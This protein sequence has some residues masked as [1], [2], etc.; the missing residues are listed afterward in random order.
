MITAFQ[1]GITCRL[2]PLIVLIVIW[3]VPAQAGRLEDIENGVRSSSSPSIAAD[4]GFDP[5]FLLAPFFQPRC[6]YPYPYYYT[7]PEIDLSGIEVPVTRN[8]SLSA[9]VHYLYDTR[10]DLDGYRGELLFGTPIGKLGGD[11]TRF[12]EDLKPGHDYLNLY[13]IDYR[14]GFDLPGFTFDVGGGYSGLYRD[15]AYGGG[16]VL[17]AIEAWPLTPLGFDATVRY[18]NIHHSGLGDYRAGINLVYRWGG[19]RVGY[20]YLHFEDGPDI[21]GPEFGIKFWL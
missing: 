20:R 12:Q 16:N 19:L 5:S 17:L 9:G 13:Y 6:Y 3:N 11:F 1:R 7:E 14:L 15:H 10:G 18:S 2:L 4:D 8:F 21:R